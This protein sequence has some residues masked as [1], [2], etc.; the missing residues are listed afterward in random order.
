V[1]RSRLGWLGPIIVIVGVA[2]AAVG[3]WYMVS[4]KPKA[5]AVIETVKVDDRRTIAIRAEDG[6]SRNFVELRDGDEVRWQALIPPYAGRPGAT[7][8]AWSPTVV[9]VRVARDGRAEVF[10]LAMEDSAKVGGLRLAPEHEQIETQPDGP[11]TLTDHIRS[12]EVVGGPDWHQLIAI[13]LQTGRGLWKVDLGPIQI[14]DG[15]VAGG[16]VWLQQG[17]RKRRFVVFTGA[18][19]RSGDQI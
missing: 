6:G 4:A 5:G 2:I 18:E 17:A 14:T 16:I 19:D 9:S 11:V 8:V 7:G 12:Y 13:S 3:V 1:A 15:A 10:A